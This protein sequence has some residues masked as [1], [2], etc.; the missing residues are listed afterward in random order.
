MIIN[1]VWILLNG[2]LCALAVRLL[3]GDTLKGFIAGVV[4]KLILTFVPLYIVYLFPFASY[5]VQIV[6]L[7]ALVFFIVK[8]DVTK[9]ALAA[10]LTYVLVFAMGFV[11][12]MLPIPIPTIV[13]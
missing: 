13:I 10:V 8:L 3:G 12:V 7:T 9:S 4:Y 6:V 1:P 5:I 2:L 11:L